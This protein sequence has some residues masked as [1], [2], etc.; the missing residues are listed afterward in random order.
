MFGTIWRKGALAIGAAVMTVGFAKADGDTIRLV[1]RPSFD[2]G[3]TQRLDLAT[4]N[5]A[6]TLLTRG[7]RGG[8]GG[9]RG[10]VAVARGGGGR[11]GFAVA[12][13]GGRGGFAVA[14]RG[15]RGGFAV[16]GRGGF[17]VGRGGFAG[18]N[19][20]FYGRGWGGWGRGGWGY[21]RG[22]GG[23]GWSGWGYPYYSGGYWPYY[24][25]PYY[26]TYTYPYDSGISYGNGGYGPQILTLQYD[27]P[28]GVPQMPRIDD[29][30]PMSPRSPDGTYPYDG[31]P[32]NPV[33]MP[34][35]QT[36][37][38]LTEPLE[39]KVSVPA[40]EKKYAFSAYGNAGTKAKPTT[41]VA[42]SKP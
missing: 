17:A 38:N 10:G 18:V 39:R 2:D 22:W 13:R 31:G 42:S 23:W 8:G 14:G 12:G 28:Q 26:S 9:G 11:G 36:A 29:G 1:D 3:A 27:Y 4:D 37:P 35:T 5:D 19:R 21:G 40:A 7:G 16:A 41:I 30:V 25:Y 6:D 32:S 33:P 34:K 20:G 15:G 24:S